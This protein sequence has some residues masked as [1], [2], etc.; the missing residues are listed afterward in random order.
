[1][2]NRPSTVIAHWRIAMP[3]HITVSPTT[4]TTQV[5]GVIAAPGTSLASTKPP[6]TPAAT[7]AM[8][9]SRLP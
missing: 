5:P 2:K 1:M 6:A 7:D 9:T 8:T 4:N 3:A